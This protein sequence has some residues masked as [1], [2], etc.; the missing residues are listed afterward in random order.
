M[1]PPSFLRRKAAD[2]AAPADDGG[3]LQQA[4]AQARRRLIGA[5]VLLAIGVI[6]F[7]IL[8]E[9]QPRPIPADIPIQVA[10]KDGG[11]VTVA[12]RPTPAPQP[13]APPADPAPEPAVAASVPVAP[14]PAAAVEPKAEAK[15]EAKAEAK[16]E[17][18]P[19]IKPEPKPEKKPEAKP[20]ASAPTKAQPA[21]AAADPA[22]AAA[23]AAPL[24]GRYV[25]QVGAFT[26]NVAMREARQKVEKLGLKTYT[27]VIETDSGRRTRVRVGPFE[28]R[29]EADKASVKLKG[30]GLP[31]YIL[32]L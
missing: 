26:D 1:A 19:D 8:F 13:V 10:R 27:Q 12:P 25:V 15:P 24:T 6:L 2:A 18:K 17:P 32:V 23:S 30:A 11:V 5:V 3:P 14:P 22:S 7:P 29:D 31:A 9:T 20:A 4:R 16:P 28:T 21:P